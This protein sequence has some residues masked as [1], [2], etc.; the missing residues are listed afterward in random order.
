LAGPV[1][2]DVRWVIEIVGF[3]GDPYIA[4]VCQ[5]SSLL[6]CADSDDMAKTVS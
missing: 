1:E 5:E 3:E 6:G 2:I 4:T